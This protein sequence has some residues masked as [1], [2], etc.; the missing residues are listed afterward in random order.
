MSFR[1]VNEISTF[2]FE[3]CM[4]TKFEMGETDLY[5][6]LEAL[7]VKANNSQ[8]TNYTESYA[9]LVRVRLQGAKV[10]SGYQ[11]GSK[12]YDA[13]DVLIREIPDKPFTEKELQDFLKTCPGNYL[14]CMEPVKAEEGSYEY[15]VGIEYAEDNDYGSTVLDSFRLNICF[16]KAIFEWDRYMNRVQR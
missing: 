13:N 12:Y 2:S 7:I 1:S 9:G 10:L 3:D 6:E 15:S 11:E 8:N 16:E 14:Y 5:M 4:V